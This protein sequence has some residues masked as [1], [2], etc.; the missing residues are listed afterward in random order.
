MDEVPTLMTIVKPFVDDDDDEVKGNGDVGLTD[1]ERGDRVF[2]L[3]KS[4]EFIGDS[5]T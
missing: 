5:Y 2:F 4:L 3:S 1:G